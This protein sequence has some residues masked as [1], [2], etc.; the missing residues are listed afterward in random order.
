MKKV[1]SFVLVLAMILGCAATAFADVSV[2]KVS[3]DNT[4]LPFDDAQDNGMATLLRDIG[5][6]QGVGDNKVNLEGKLTRAEAATIVVRA[7]GLDDLGKIPT[8]TKFKDVPADAWYSGYVAVAANQGIVDGKG[9]GIFE[10]EANISVDEC[11]ALI[12][13][14]LGYRADH[15]NGE[16]PLNF[17][18]VAKALGLLTG[19]TAGSADATR[20]DYF[21]IFFNALNRSHV[22]WVE[23]TQG[24]YVGENSDISIDRR[25]F[26]TETLFET[27]T[28]LSTTVGAFYAEGSPVVIG[29]NYDPQNF[30]NGF[31]A[32]AFKGQSVT[33]LYKIQKGG[34]KKAIGIYSVAS[35]TI[36]G[37]FVAK[38]GET[39]V[40]ESFK[41]LDGETYKFANATMSATW[42][43]DTFE[44]GTTKAGT[45]L[46]TTVPYKLT[47]AF[48]TE[49]ANKI[50]NIHAVSYWTVNKVVV[51]S[52]TLAGYFADMNIV[53][54]N[55]DTDLGYDFATTKAS[56]TSTKKVYLADSCIVEGDV[57]ALDEIEAD[58]VLEVYVDNANTIV[59]VVVTRDKVVGTVSKVVGNKYTVN[60]STYDKAATTV[61]AFEVP[62]VTSKASEYAFYLDSTGK[63][64][65]AELTKETAT[66]NYQYGFITG[67]K[68]VLDDKGTK[69]KQPVT[70]ASIWITVPG[71]DEVLYNTDKCLTTAS[72]FASEYEPGALVKFEVVDDELKS[73]EVATSV[74]T[75]STKISK[76]GIFGDRKVNAD[77]KVFQVVSEAAAELM[78]PDNFKALDF[79]DIK[80]KTFDKVLTVAGAKASDIDVVVVYAKGS[81]SAKASYITGAAYIADLGHD[82][83]NDV[84]VISLLVFGEDDLVE[85]E[86]DAAPA[87][88][89]TKVYT[90][91]L[92]DGAYKS[93]AKT[94]TPY[95]LVSANRENAEAATLKDNAITVGT[96]TKFLAD[97][98]ETWFYDETAAPASKNFEVAD[99][100]EAISDS[101]VDT[102]KLVDLDEDGAF[103]I[104]ILVANKQ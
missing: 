7:L 92:E 98:F 39:A 83:E 59:K 96:T 48:D 69:T 82:V 51:V 49:D 74:E 15:L 25:W 90:L 45:T 18:Y 61:A 76:N 101:Y 43:G 31:D 50:T 19:V 80:D 46:K 85:L 4:V 44:N 103:D 97:D 104:V 13:K 99:F 56:A 65:Y 9:N 57:D 78:N 79:S 81:V 89:K 26:Q 3:A 27:I 102:I 23:N 54:I 94:Y 37:N 47:V 34:A 35:K 55:A 93:I 6:L 62:A 58:D 17:R 38:R 33:I 12:A 36:E 67:F 73:V 88:D 60:G 5:V 75:A 22:Q 20:E 10:P 70:Y 29:K 86:L 64:V 40:F 21:T 16:W 95:E 28:G 71:E 52:T 77:T 14:V 53:K 87:F 2:K 100:E 11:I 84:Y 66:H 30:A 63:Y 72:V 41:T 91:E 68:A 8:K 1:L 32:S 42:T 24:G